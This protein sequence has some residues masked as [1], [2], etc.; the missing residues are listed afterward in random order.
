VRSSSKN[1]ADVPTTY[2]GEIGTSIPIQIDHL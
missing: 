1:D 2:S